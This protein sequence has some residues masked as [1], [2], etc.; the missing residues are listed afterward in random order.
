MSIY[1]HNK[2]AGF[3]LWEVV[4][5]LVIVAFLCVF[6]YP[7]FQL[8]TQKPSPRAKCLDNLREIATASQMY[9]QDNDGMLYT[10]ERPCRDPKTQRP[11]ICPAYFDASAGLTQTAQAV[12]G[13]ASPQDYRLPANFREPGTLSRQYWP[14]VL[15]PY[16]NS[17]SVFQCPANAAN[18]FTPATNSAYVFPGSQEAVGSEGKGYGVENSYAYNSELGASGNGVP[19]AKVNRPAHTILLSDATFFQAYF[20]AE[21]ASGATMVTRCANGKDCEQELRRL[22][23]SYFRQYWQNIGDA[24]FSQRG[25]PLPVADALNAGASCHKGVINVAYADGHVRAERYEDVI[26]DPCL[27]VIDTY[28]AH[29]NCP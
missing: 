4:G 27:W 12:F 1:S 8:A 5:V 17:W 18:P 14:A 6:L 2:R 22:G 25:S 20:D 11:V 23:R 15:Y 16:I 29:P 9:V 28:A 7:V 13:V 3:T 24:N 19:F 10:A 21:N 26:H